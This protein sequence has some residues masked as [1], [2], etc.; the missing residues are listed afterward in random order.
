MAWCQGSSAAARPGARGGTQSQPPGVAAVAGG[1]LRVATGSRSGAIGAAIAVA[2]A[3]IATALARGHGH[4]RPRC[5]HHGVSARSASA[6][7][8]DLK[9]LFS[10]RRGF[11]KVRP[12]PEGME[13]IGESLWFDVI[14]EKPLGLRLT[15]GPNGAGGGVGIAEIAGG[16]AGDLLNK[17]CGAGAKPCLYAQ[18]GDELQAIN[19]D[20]ING[21]QQTA[22]GKIME[23]EGSVTLTLSRKKQ[24][25]ITVVFPNGNIV[26]TPRT[27]IL[28]QVAEKAGYST[29]CVCKNG[30][31]GKCWHEDPA[32]GEL[33]M[34]PINCAGYVPS[35]FRKR[36]ESTAGV[37]AN[38]ESWVPL[39]L[40]PCPE[41]FK[42][43]MATDGESE[44]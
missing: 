7:G 26:T 41:R 21:D 15:D 39:R 4:L 24:G 16:S 42:K 35:I 25:A 37:E 2:G 40:E 38:Y 20:G 9:S 17:A 11:L 12:Y 33:Y 27:A 14:L 32:T 18:E 23:S 5:R 29:G 34:F 8:F 28:S 31:C 30:R 6:G 22:I 13:E 44:A 3:A 19:G 36:E 10:E 1:G 43:F